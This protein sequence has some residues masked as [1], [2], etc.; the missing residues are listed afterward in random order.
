[1]EMTPDQTDMVREWRNLYAAV[2]GAVGSLAYIYAIYFGFVGAGRD[3]RDYLLS[4][5]RNR[6]R[7]S[8]VRVIWFGVVGAATAAVFQL[9]QSE[10]VPIQSFILGATWPSIVSQVLSGRQAGPTEDEVRRELESRRTQTGLGDSADLR[11]SRVVRRRETASEFDELLRG[12]SR[13]DG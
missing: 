9:P 13:D 5:F 4:G 2:V 12:G 10:F 3:S 1:M 6:T 8:S 7:M 11:A